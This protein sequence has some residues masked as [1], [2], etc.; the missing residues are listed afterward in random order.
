MKTLLTLTALAALA[1]LT[2]CGQSGPLKL[3]ESKVVVSTPAA[4]SDAEAQQ[5]KTPPIP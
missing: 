4:A 1:L 3:P 5:S 2:A